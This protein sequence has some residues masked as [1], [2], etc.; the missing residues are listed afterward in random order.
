MA[1]R[2]TKAIAACFCTCRI[3]HI[4]QEKRPVLRLGLESAEK[5]DKILPHVMQWLHGGLAS[6]RLALHMQHDYL[7]WHGG[8]SL[9]ITQI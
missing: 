9:R 7:A 4:A 1:F 3:Q 8:I 5:D 2:R 6:Y